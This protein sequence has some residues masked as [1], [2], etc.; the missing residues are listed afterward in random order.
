MIKF[1]ILLIANII[2]AYFINYKISKIARVI[3]FQE[4]ETE[5]EAKL[6]FYTLL[7]CVIFWTIYLS[8]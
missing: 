8:I 1:L 3:A 5:K 7:V 6:S 4:Q 2:T